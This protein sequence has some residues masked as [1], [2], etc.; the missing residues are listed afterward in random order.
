MHLPCSL[1][2]QLIRVASS[3]PLN[4]SEGS[5][6]PTL[7]DRMRFYA[8]VFAS[9]REV[10]ALIDLEPETLKSIHATADRLGANLYCLC[11]R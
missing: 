11:R 10:Q 7:K 4:L 9:L 8:I 6:K 3:V 2:D 5:A 1:K